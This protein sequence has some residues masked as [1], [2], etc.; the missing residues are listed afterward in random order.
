MSPLQILSSIEPV[1]AKSRSV[2][3]HADRIGPA[4]TLWGNIALAPPSWQHPC[5]FF[6]DSQKTLRWIFVLDILNHCFWPE[7][8][9]S[10]WSVLYK[11]QTF[12]GYWGLAAALKRAQESGIPLTEPAFLAD[13]DEEK[14]GEI[15]SFHGHGHRNHPAQEPIPLFL[16]RLKNLREAGSTMLQEPGTDIE[17]LLE[18]ARE[19][20]QNLA[21][22]VVSHFPS[23][24]DEGSYE[25]EKVYFW[26]RA[27]IF[28]SDVF[29]AFGGKKWGAFRDMDHLTAFADYKLPQ[30]LRA[31]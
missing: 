16:E 21:C 23:F 15:F 18:A 8:G 2:L 30:V 25:G 6:D 31:L 28:V 19:S 14:L 7:R 3:F 22:L 26:K 11:G 13:I 20:A 12:S 29:T 9:K 24:R 4:V 10:A 27:Q 17:A 5:H 1:A